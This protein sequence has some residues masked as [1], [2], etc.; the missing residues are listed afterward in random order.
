MAASPAAGSGRGG[1]VASAGPWPTK[2]GAMAGVAVCPNGL[3]QRWATGGGIPDRMR[4][5][6]AAGGGVRRQDEATAA[7]PLQRPQGAA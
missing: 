4:R 3:R 2:G 5:Q 1:G 7:W 6:Q